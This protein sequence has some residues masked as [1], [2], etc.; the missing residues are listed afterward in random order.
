[1]IPSIGA[2]PTFNGNAGGNGISPSLLYCH[3]NVCWNFCKKGTPN[4]NHRMNEGSRGA[5]RALVGEKKE[6]ER[7][8]EGQAV[9]GA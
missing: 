6:G 4:E 9:C 8:W 5:K 1:M 2:S 7:E 3:R